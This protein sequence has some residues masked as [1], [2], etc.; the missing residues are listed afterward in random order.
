MTWQKVWAQP[1]QGGASR[2]HALA[3]R[4]GFGA[5]EIMLSTRVMLSQKEEDQR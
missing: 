4:P 3:D 2:P 5:N 1:T